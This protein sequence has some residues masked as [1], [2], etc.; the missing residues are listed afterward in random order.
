M[1]CVVSGVRSENHGDPGRSHVQPLPTTLGTASQ[2]QRHS[3][4]YL[5]GD[6]EQAAKHV[7]EHVLVPGQ[8]RHRV[9]PL[10]ACPEQHPAGVSET[11]RLA[12]GGI[13]WR[14]PSDHRLPFYGTDEPAVVCE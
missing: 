2:D 14:G 1:S 4:G 12:S 13:Q 5:Q 8:Q 9:Y 7:T 6:E 3:D 10:Q 11:A